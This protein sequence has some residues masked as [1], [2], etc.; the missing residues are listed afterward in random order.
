MTTS[1]EADRVDQQGIRK[2]AGKYRN[3]CH[4]SLS[5]GPQIHRHDKFCDDRAT[6]NGGSKQLLQ[7]VKSRFYHFLLFYGW[8]SEPLSI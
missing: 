2:H 1:A 5:P 6:N 8:M 4:P 3:S 7:T